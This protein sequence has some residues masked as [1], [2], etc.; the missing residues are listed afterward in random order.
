MINI[1]ICYL[2]WV[3][4]QSEIDFDSSTVLFLD[5]Y[6]NYIIFQTMKVSP[7]RRWLPT[8]LVCLWFITMGKLNNCYKFQCSK[9][10]PAI[11]LRS[12]RPPRQAL[13]Y[14]LL[15]KIKMYLLYPSFLLFNFLLAF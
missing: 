4:I 9:P 12:Q 10:V 11:I 5:M 2:I 8:K 6:K 15:S 7:V 1:A 13:N 14:G 3:S